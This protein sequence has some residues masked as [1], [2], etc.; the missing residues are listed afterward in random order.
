MPAV[1]MKRKRRPLCSTISSTASRVVPGMGETM[2]RSEAVRQFSSVDLP[3]L[4]WPMMA[5]LV[6]WAFGRS[7]VVASF[8][9]SSSV[10]LRVTASASV[11]FCVLWMVQADSLL[12]LRRKN[13]NHRVQQIVDAA[14]VLGGDGEHLRDAE[15]VEVVDQRRLFFAVDFVD[16]EEQRPVGFAQQAREFEVGAGE[17]GASVDDHDDGGGFVE[18][19][20]GLAKDFRRDQIFFF[21]EDAAGVDDAQLAA[22]PFGIAVEA[23]AGDAG[24]VADNGAA[25]AHDAVEERGLADIGAADD[26]DGGNAGGGGGDGAG[27][28]VGGLGQD[29]SLV[30][31]GGRLGR[32]PVRMGLLPIESGT[33]YYRDS[34]GLVPSPPLPLRVASPRG[35]DA[36]LHQFFAPAECC[37]AP[38]LRMNFGADSCRWRRPSSRRWKKSGI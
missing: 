11:C 12:C 31:A 17:F 19:D 22:F 36:S 10:V 20:A 24:F 29:V 5:T 27:R 7:L 23:V 25:R 37:R 28:I 8:G 1:S 32:R 38:I 4:G 21:G 26:G 14:A 3:T 13:G 18:G 35:K 30:E 15:A 6:S 33:R 2:A 34:R 9:L 16:G